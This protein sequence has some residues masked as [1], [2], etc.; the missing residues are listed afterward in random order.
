MVD[1]GREPG[2]WA[3]LVQCLSSNGS[4]RAWTASS[5]VAHRVIAT[6]SRILQMRIIERQASR[7]LSATELG[8]EQIYARQHRIPR[9]AGPRALFTGGPARSD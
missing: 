4:E 5:P 3:V 7:T 9:T 8:A 2:V 6:N 1:A